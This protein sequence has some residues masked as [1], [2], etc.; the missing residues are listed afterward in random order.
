[1]AKRKRIAVVYG[2]GSTYG[3]GYEVE[4]TPP[5]KHKDE[6][7]QSFFCKPPMD[8]SFFEN[9]RL[10]ELSLCYPSIKFFTRGYFGF[11]ENAT[12]AEVGLEEVWSAIDLNQKHIHLE[13]YGWESESEKYLEFILAKRDFEDL[14]EQDMK[15]SFETSRTPSGRTRFK[16]LGDCGRH[17]H[18]L[19][20]RVYGFPKLKGIDAYTELHKQLLEKDIDVEY[21][22]F[23]YDACLEKSLKRGDFEFGYLSDVERIVDGLYREEFSHILK[24]H[25]SLTWE[26]R[27]SNSLAPL[28]LPQTF[29]PWDSSGAPY[30]FEPIQPDYGERN[31]E[32]AIIPP[33]WSKQD[34]NDD[35]H[36]SRSRLSQLILH[37]WRSAL[38]ALKQADAVVIVGYSF[39][40]SDLHAQR[41]FRLTAMTRNTKG[42][43]GE[44][45]RVAWCRGEENIQESKRDP[46]RG[47]VPDFLKSNGLRLVSEVSE[48]Q[49]LCNPRTFRETLS[50]LFP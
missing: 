3:S 2:S 38:E 28:R 26:H 1:M 21:I 15:P 40:P 33:T 45:L 49:N 24:L 18:H 35:I 17:L 29:K 41:L 11:S 50:K 44:P 36:A 19:I 22:T 23:N 12:P 30:D 39:P 9:P 10:W 14:D 34:I 16:F 32:M 20:Y 5:R 47:T 7:V 13:T 8:K 42:D 27:I 37:Q 43:G 6:N 25:G 31:T 46:S 4:I 48:F